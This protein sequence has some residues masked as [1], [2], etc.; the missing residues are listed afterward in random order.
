MALASTIKG[1]LVSYKKKITE[2]VALPSAFYDIKGVV[3]LFINNPKRQTTYTFT[4]FPGLYSPASAVPCRYDLCLFDPQGETVFKHAVNLPVFGTVAIQPKDLFQG[5]LPELGMISARIRPVSGFRYPYAHLGTLRSHFY[6]MYHDPD[7]RSMALVHPQCMFQDPPAP[8]IG[9][10][11][12]LLIQVNGL[13]FLDVYQINPGPA[14]VQTD[15]YMTDAKG[16][17]IISSPG[18]L[19]PYGARCVTWPKSIFASHKYVALGMQGLP[20]ENAKPLVFNN[21]KDGSFSASH[22]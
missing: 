19:R 6:A 8:T 15:L 17:K 9:W 7:M 13:E 12:D 1:R 18:E 2:S 14:A 20:A 11:S 22:S 3:Q 4:N 21:F 5:P 16:K 10:W